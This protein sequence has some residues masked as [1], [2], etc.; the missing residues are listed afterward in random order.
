MSGVDRDVN[1][2]KKTSEF[3]TPTELVDMSLDK[4]EEFDPMLF[5]DPERTFL[6]S[7]CGD[8]QFL[9][10]ILERKIKNDIPYDKAISTIYGVELMPD[11]A[12]MCRK[13][14]LSLYD[15]NDHDKMN[16]IVNQNIVC[17]D[18][19]TYHFRFDGSDPSLSNSDVLFNELF[20]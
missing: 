6:D 1:R 13:R 5:I 3:F 7:S 10:R 18:A 19:L 4:M 9:V 17:A 16:N 2:I 8:E 14:I 20:E 11:N 15:G 12:D